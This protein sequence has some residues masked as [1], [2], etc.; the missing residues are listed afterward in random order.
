MKNNAAI[1]AVAAI[2]AFVYVW[3]YHRQRVKR[4]LNN[5][6]TSIPTSLVD[7]SNQGGRATTSP[8]FY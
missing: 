1:I 7:S 3:M 5:I 8:A 6:S 4:A 2:A